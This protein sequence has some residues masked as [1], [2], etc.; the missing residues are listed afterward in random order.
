MLAVYIGDRL[1]LYRILAERGPTTSGELADAAGLHERY[2]REW[3]EQQASSAILEVDDARAD[4]RCAPLRAAAGSRRGAGRRHEP[5]L[6][7]ADRPARGRVR[8]ADGRRAG[9]LSHAATASRTPTTAPTCTRARRASRGRCSTTLLASEWLPARSRRCTSG[10]WPIRRR[11]SPTSRAARGARASRSPAAIRRSASTASTWTRPRSRRRGGHLAGSGRG[12]PSRVPPARRRRRRARRQLRPRDIL[13]A[14][15]DMSYP[16]AGPRGLP[17][18][19][20]R[21]RLGDRR[22]RARGRRVRPPGRRDRALLLRLQRPALPARRHGRRGR[23]RHRD[24]DAR[25]HRASLRRRGRVRR[26][27]GAADRARLL[28]LLPAH[29]ISAITGRCR[30]GSARRA[31]AARRS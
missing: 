28:S 17:R 12:R 18:A 22:R 26:L 5:Q 7:R 10:C 24:G 2:V 9:G 13:E 19:A 20:G 8:E 1:G 15:H 23:R 21:R 25:R 16:V 14:L 31:A 30:R 6:H 27:R 29:P 4:D 3:L 11:A